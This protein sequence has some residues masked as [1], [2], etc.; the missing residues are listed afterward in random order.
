MD[1]AEKAYAHYKQQRRLGLKTKI[2]HYCRY[3]I[4]YE[5]GVDLRILIT[6]IV[7]FIDEETSDRKS[8][9]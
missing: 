4:A 2:D 5:P 8:D 9:E 3:I 7:D 1:T 6:R